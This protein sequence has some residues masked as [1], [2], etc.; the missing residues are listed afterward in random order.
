MVN[1]KKGFVVYNFQLLRRNSE[2]I[3][4]FKKRFSEFSKLH[5]SLKSRYTHL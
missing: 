1:E 3:A 2:E 4:V 5:L